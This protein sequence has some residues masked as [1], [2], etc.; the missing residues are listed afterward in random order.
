M[1]RSCITILTF[2]LACALQAGVADSSTL[3][4]QDSVF[5]SSLFLNKLIKGEDQV[6]VYYGT[7]LTAGGA[8]T[9]LLTEE[10]DERFPGLVS[11]SNQGGPGMHSGWGLE[12]V[13]ERV[14]A[15]APDVVFLEFS[16]NDAVERFHI[17]PQQAKDNLNQMIDRILE[18]R[19]D[20]EIILQIMNPVVGHPEGDPSWRSTLPE[21]QENYREV[22]AERGLLLIDHMPAW[23]Q[24]LDRDAS[25]FN[26]YVPDGV[27][28]SEAGWQ[29]IVMPELKAKLGLARSVR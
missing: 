25:T 18:A 5:M 20:C 16:M 29:T 27:H 17:P 14:V 23:T 26:E 22:A 10:L 24:L 28:P 11:A 21:C 1:I 6:I 12:H 3:L 2:V 9:R 15:L 8:W 19:T 4:G 13:D 7:S